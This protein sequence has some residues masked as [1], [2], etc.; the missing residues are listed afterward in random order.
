MKAKKTWLAMLLAVAAFQAAP[1]FAAP[2]GE[3]PD[4]AVILMYHHVSATAPASTSVAPGLF[5]EHLAYLE[6]HGFRVWSLPAVVDSLAG[7]GA[8]PDSVV[9]FTFDD[10]YRSVYEEAFP[11]LRRRGWPFTVFV[12]TDAIDNGEG[13]VLSWDQLREMAA[14][15]ATIASHGQHHRHLQ[16]RLPGETEDQW[17]Q[18]TL[19]E[20]RHSGRRIRQE[21]GQET[22][23]LAY[24][25]GEHDER[26]TRLVRQL[27]WTAFGQQSGPAGVTSDPAA[28][29]RFPMAAGFASMEGFP[30]KAASLPLPVVRAE[31]QDLVLIFG[32][33]SVIL[34]AE[35]PTLKLTLAAGDYQAGQLAAYSG[36][37]GRIE[38]RWSDRA[39]GT[40][41]ITATGP[42]GPGR[43]RYNVTAPARDGRRWYWYSHTW[44]A[45]QEHGD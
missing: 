7:G 22:D 27:G 13:P 45:G 42:L 30:V 2:G 29:P 23:L 3:L 10:G 16:R 32:T 18:R 1:V 11:R 36:G 41:E 40:L 15:G 43:S 31:P 35:A 26:L 44:I 33:G 14:Q 19:G 34:G 9:V 38:A 6:K 37:Q 21:I 39:A 17:R 24:P 25:Y 5:E 12:T 8:L 28:L 20:L 4:H